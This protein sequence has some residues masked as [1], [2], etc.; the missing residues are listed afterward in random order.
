MLSV[1]KKMV[2]G[3]SEIA[4]PR[5]CIC[6]GVEITPQKKRLC[7]FCRQKRFV[8]ANPTHSNYCSD[9]LLPESVLIQHAMWKF[10]QGGV[11]QDLM[12]Y[13]KYERMV[14]IGRELG[15]LMAK[16]ALRHPKIKK[17][18][19]CQQP[20]VV[21]V[22]LHYLKFRKRGFNQAFVLAQGFRQITKLKICSI[23]CVIRQKNTKTQTGF[24]IKDR[25]ANIKDAFV[26]KKR[27]ELVNQTVII[28]DDVFTTGS[29]TFELAKTLKNAGTGP[30]LILTV[31][32]A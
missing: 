29:T 10:D 7:S 30:I 23:D 26:V 9:V 20:L 5:V 24:L 3:L 21:P 19:A 18:I 17:I 16:R 14:D 12:H 1:F 25:L 28:V 22:P 27:S 31:A 15:T 6:C 2:S 11:L 13:L 8:D 32:Q 4:F